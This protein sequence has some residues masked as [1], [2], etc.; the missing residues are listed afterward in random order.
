MVSNGT[1]ALV[2][3]GANTTWI[4]WTNNY[5]VSSNYTLVSP[6]ILDISA[7]GDT[8]LNLGH[9]AAQTLYGN[10]TLIGNLLVTNSLIV[11]ARRASLGA[12]YFTGSGLAVSGSVTIAG[13]STVLMTVN[14]TNTPANDSLT[15]AS[16]V[17]GGTIIVTNA[18]DTAFP[19]LSSNV[20]KLFNGAISGTF[21]NIILA[22]N[23]L[24]VNEFWVDHLNLDGS[25][26]LVNSASGINTNPPAVMVSFNGTQLALGWP[27]NAGWILQSQTNPL[28]AGL[29]TPSNTWFDV[30]GSASIT[31]TVI[32]VTPTNPT[33]F[34]RLR[35]P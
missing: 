20:F 28:S 10:G 21:T 31:N 12:T 2:P 15:A 6:G 9:N 17:Y 16:I 26:A 5:L 18:G 23:N 14:R 33:V 24:P 3:T 8:T 4:N 34:Y 27:T 22:T 19:G 29:T 35:L 32:T 13:G 30:A 7:V 25:V 11:P 1:L